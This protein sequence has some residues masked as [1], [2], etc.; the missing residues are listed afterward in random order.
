M[1]QSKLESFLA[2]YDESSQLS[3]CETLGRL[4]NSSISEAQSV[5]P[6]IGG[7]DVCFAAYLGSRIPDDT[8]PVDALSRLKITDL[9]LA[10]GCVEG[11]NAALTAFSVQFDEM[12]EG[13]VRR[14]ARQGFDV[15]DAKQDVLR[16]ILFP[17]KSRAAAIGLYAGHGSLSG[18]LG[19]TVVREV[20]RMIKALDRQAPM[21][22]QD[23]AIE[24]ADVSDDPEL[25]VLKNR[26]RSEFKDAFQ[27]AF[28]S[29]GAAERN[30]LRYYY[31]SELTLMQIA[32]ISGVKHNTISRQLAKIRS[33][34]L[35]NTRAHLMANAGIRKTQFQSIVRL[36]QSQLHVS[37]C[38]MLSSEDAPDDA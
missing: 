9:Y 18:Y 35:D 36:V 14:F 38:R 6:D 23:L 17:T 13:A 29:L 15:E 8:D 33:T 31:V 21:Q 25:R 10:W 1:L 3:D 12:V 5:W 32:S 11:D 4:L 2:Q 28:A 24:L 7:S 20:L 37:M 16:H 27:Q 26:Y 19:V 30:L 34:L 22:G